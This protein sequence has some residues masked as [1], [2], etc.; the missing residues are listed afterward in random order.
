MDFTTECIALMYPVIYEEDPRRSARK[1]LTEKDILQS[2]EQNDIIIF[3]IRTQLILERK[4]PHPAV[5]VK[6]GLLA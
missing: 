4:H 6:T 3:L 5:H 2:D 1:Q